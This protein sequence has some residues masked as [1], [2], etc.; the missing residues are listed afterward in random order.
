MGWFLSVLRRTYLDVKWGTLFQSYK[1]KLGEALL[2]I[3]EHKTNKIDAVERFG[4]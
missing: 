1:D 4:S 2:S 3:A